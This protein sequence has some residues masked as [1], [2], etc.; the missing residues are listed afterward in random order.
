MRLQQYY[1]LLAE[2][3]AMQKIVLVFLSLPV[4]VVDH[5]D[6]LHTVGNPHLEIM[7]SG[8]VLSAFLIPFRYIRPPNQDSPLVTRQ[9]F[10]KTLYL[11]Y[12][13]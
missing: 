13:I 9:M 6:G 2:H 4:D 5:K 7:F 11:T 8:R 3:G 10:L 1:E 12:R